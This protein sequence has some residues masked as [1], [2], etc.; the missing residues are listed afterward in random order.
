MDWVLSRAPRTGNTVYTAPPTPQRK[1]TIIA[2][3]GAITRKRRYNVR[4]CGFER[5]VDSP[6]AAGAVVGD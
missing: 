1:T 2:F 6:S 5:K 3:N 4:I